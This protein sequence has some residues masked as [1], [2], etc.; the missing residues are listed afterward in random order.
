MININFRFTETCQCPRHLYA[1]WYSYKPFIYSS[2]T[3]KHVTSSSSVKGF[4]AE[5]VINATNAICQ[6]C[7]GTSNHSFG[8]V[9]LHFGR[10]KDG[11]VAVFES[12]LS[13]DSSFV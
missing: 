8:G 13:S 1:S 4:L 6:I 10:R 9:H 2:A 11:W 12:K 7:D 5:F 3:E